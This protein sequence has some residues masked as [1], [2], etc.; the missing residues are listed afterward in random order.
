[1]IWLLMKKRV[2]KITHSVC[3]FF[4]HKILLIVFCSFKF[5]HIQFFK[6]SSISH[7]L[8]THKNIHQGTKHNLLCKHEV[9][10]VFYIDIDIYCFSTFDLKYIFFYQ[11]QIYNPMKYV[12]LMFL[13]RLILLSFSV[14]L[15]LH[16]AYTI[17]YISFIQ[18]TYPTRW[19]LKSIKT[20]FTYI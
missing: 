1:M 3:C 18:N 11:I 15:S 4:Y 5:L 2:N 10:I 14:L 7:C 19:F 12:L 9:L 16:L 6:N 17:F 8:S 13:L 20:S